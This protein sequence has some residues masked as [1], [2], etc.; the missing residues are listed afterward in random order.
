MGFLM[1]CGSKSMYKSNTPF[2]YKK[3]FE[4]PH[5]KE[6]YF[7]AGVKRVVYKKLGTPLLWK[8]VRYSYYK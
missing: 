3:P 1:Y 6:G 4:G 7:L 5:R 2:R 8:V